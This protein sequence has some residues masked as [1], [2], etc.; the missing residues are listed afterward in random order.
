MATGSERGSRR[1]MVRRVAWLC[2]GLFLMSGAF[3]STFAFRRRIFKPRPKVPIYR[4]FAPNPMETDVAGAIRTGT[5]RG[6]VLVVPPDAAESFAGAGGAAGGK[7]Q[8]SRL[9][10]G[11]DRW[12]AVTQ[13][14]LIANRREAQPGD[15]VVAQWIGRYEGQ[16]YDLGALATEP[17]QVDSASADLVRR[18][19]GTSNLFVVSPTAKADAIGKEFRLQS[20]LTL[21][22]GEPIRGSATVRVAAAE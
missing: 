21:P 20:T 3:Q 13:I 19:D 15:S 14:Q 4:E 18:V 7:E 6:T 10:E 11:F 2:V 9:P 5:S 22:G 17:V 16:L 8:I 1:G 12:A